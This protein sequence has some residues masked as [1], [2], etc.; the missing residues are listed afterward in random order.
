MTPI[1]RMYSLAEMHLN[2]P[3]IPLHI[4]LECEVES[5]SSRK[6]IGV[7]QATED[8]SLRN[9]GIEFISKPMPVTEAIS[10]FKN[11]HATIQYHDKRNA[12]TPRTSTHVHI[13]CRALSA[14]HTK[15]IALLYALYE[16]CFFS[17]V[18][19]DRRNNIHCVPL[20]ETFLPMLYRKPLDAL[21][22]RWHKYTALNLLPLAKYGTIEFRHLQGTDD[23]ELLN[24]WLTALQNLWLLS[25]KIDINQDSLVNKRTLD[26]WFESIFGHSSRVLALRPALPELMS[27]SLLDVKLSVLKD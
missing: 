13:N 4:G 26:I 2:K 24:E 16:E 17:M 19:Q 7:F 22:A 27:N 20:S 25:Q 11:L 23:A 14:E 21:V 9:S 15:N 3:D 6:S 12:F 5:V 18:N 1:W 10:Q 8:G